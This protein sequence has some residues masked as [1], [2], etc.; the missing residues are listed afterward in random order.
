MNT[1]RLFFGLFLCF[2][3]TFSV[4]VNAQRKK[5]T[6]RKAETTAPVSDQQSYGSTNS[7]KTDTFVKPTIQ[8]TYQFVKNNL[9]ADADSVKMS[10]RNDASVERTLIKDRQPLAYEHIREEDA[11]YR[12]K[13]WRE[14]DGREKMNLSFRYKNNE[15]NGDQ[16]LILILK[17]AIT[18]REITAF[19][20]DR[21]TTPMT[22]E[23]VVSKFSLANDTVPVPALDENSPPI[24][25]VTDNPIDYDSIYLFKLKE[26]W[27][28]DKESSRLFVRI[29]GI[30]PM[31]R[32][33]KDGRDVD[34]A[35]PSYNTLFWVYYPDCRSTFSK[36]EAYNGKNY[37]GRM[38]W[39]ELFENRLFS[40]YIT[41]TT[42]DNPFNKS[43]KEII[44]DPIYRLLEGENIKEKIFNY[45]QDL[46]SY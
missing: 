3:L 18:E 24:M 33:I 4:Q 43:L 8:Y 2:L 16:R 21:F 1:L 29:L 17:R 35:N 39:E 32:V 10:Q 28:F 20:D 46:W 7:N 34:P 13:I 12:Q 6:A 31:L 11:I 37:G 38:S 22:P 44:K 19:E 26:E 45:E 25:K 15:D 30:A 27:V 40:S 14:I 42:M 36:Y 9:N 5:K 41:K 23:Q